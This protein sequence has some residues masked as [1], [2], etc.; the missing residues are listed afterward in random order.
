MN[1]KL[2]I[3]IGIVGLVALGA[4]A[5]DANAVC[6]GKGFQTAFSSTGN[7]IYL[8]FPPDADTTIGGPNLVGRFWQTGSRALH[9]EGTTCPEV[10]YLVDLGGGSLA[11][12]GNMGGDILGTGPCLNNGCPVGSM[13]LVLQTKSLDGTKSYF[14]IGQ[15]SKNA[16]GFDFAKSGGGTFMVA[17]APRAKVTTS[18]RVGGTVNLNV[19]FDS[20]SVYAFGGEVAP[21]SVLSG[22]QVFQVVSNTDPGRAPAAWGAPVQTVPAGSTGADIPLAINCSDTGNDVWIGTRAVFDN[23]QYASDDISGAT[24]VECDPTLADPRFKNIDKRKGKGPL[25]P[26]Q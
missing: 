10:T 5:T 11:V 25:A 14:A 16:D 19:H 24:R 6:D 13:T 17:E 15:T 9:N 21:T 1:R 26:K 18:G 7:S 23:A 20:P 3:A 2:L 8:Q 22:Y 12:F 4:A